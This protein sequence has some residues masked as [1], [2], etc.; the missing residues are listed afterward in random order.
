MTGREGGK[1][2]AKRILCS[3]LL[4]LMALSLVACGPAAPVVAASTPAPT[5][6]ASLHDLLGC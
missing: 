1:G 5:A 3:L 4:G 2:M 6:A